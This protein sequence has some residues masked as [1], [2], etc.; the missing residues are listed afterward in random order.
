ML[1]RRISTRS[2][3]IWVAAI[4]TSHFQ[5]CP[6]ARKLRDLEGGAG[7]RRRYINELVAHLAIDRKL[8]ADVSKK[9]V[10]L[11]DIFHFAAD[12]LDRSF[13]IS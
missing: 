13:Q 9:G 10:K 11:D 2:M 3:P 7:G 8:R 1:R 12:A 5:K 6:L 4:S